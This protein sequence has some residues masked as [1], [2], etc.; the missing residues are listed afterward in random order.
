MKRTVQPFPEPVLG[1]S[2]PPPR[3]FLACTSVSSKPHIPWR[4]PVP[5][6]KDRASQS[7]VPLWGLNVKTHHKFSR[8]QREWKL[9]GQEKSGAVST[10]PFFQWVPD[11]TLD[12]WGASRPERAGDLS[13]ITQLYPRIL[14]QIVVCWKTVHKVAAV[15]PG[16]CS[17]RQ[18]PRSR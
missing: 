15:L 17:H 13:K 18:G 10:G 2:S 5:A 3:G 7:D 6:L 11:L 4:R 14:H 1:I 16:Q 9:T 12:V 8:G